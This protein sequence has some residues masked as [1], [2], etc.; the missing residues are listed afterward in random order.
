MTS[1]RLCCPSRAGR[2]WHTAVLVAVGTWVLPPVSPAVAQVYK[3]TGPQGQVTYSEAPCPGETSVRLDLKEPV[4]NR[5]PRRPPAA[6]APRP[7]EVAVA[8][9][10]AGPA[11]AAAGGYDLS[12]GDRQR[13][14][15]LEQLARNPSAYGEQRQ[16][17]AL[18]IFNIRKG[19]VARMSADDVRK[20]DQYW[21]DLASVEPERRRAAAEQLVGLFARYP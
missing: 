19:A 14:A 10:A 8:T 21:V 5:D 1:K 16:S 18:E 2:T 11:G 13:I 3:C 9:P 4:E 7:P 20:K 15:V 12:Y 17:A 6:P